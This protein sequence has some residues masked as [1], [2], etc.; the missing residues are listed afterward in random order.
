M[1]VNR[2]L[3]GAGLVLGCT[4]AL[5]ACK[6]DAFSTGPT[7]QA[8]SP[9]C[10]TIAIEVA[11][12]DG[13][14][15]GSAVVIAGAPSPDPAGPIAYSWTASAGFFLDATASRTTY[16][17]PRIGQS[18]PQAITLSATRGPCTVTQQAIVI[19]IEPA[20]VDP[21]AG[22]GAPGSRGG[23]AGAPGRSEDAGQSDDAGDGGVEG[24]PGWVTLACGLADSTIDEGNTCNQCTLDNCTTMENATGPNAVVT[25]GCH[26]LASDAAR[27][28]CERLYCCIRAHGC[29]IAST[30]DPTRCWCGDAD[31]TAC[32]LGTA[33]ATGP[34]L[35]EAKSAAH[36]T[37]LAQIN[38]SQ[39]DPALPIGG[40]V[41]LAICRA[42]F[43]STPAAPECA[44]YSK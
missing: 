36:T 38:Q 41:N 30:G 14:I 16:E 40:A 22:G 10:P 21:G 37:D 5:L 17:C 6:R 9:H 3:G 8:I 23:A 18:G 15:E 42:T 20:S 33:P 1:R 35:E 32:F 39:V 7:L 31:P 12:T 29:L 44:G 13:E 19:C 28:A 4:T 24:G 26:H 11:D 25:A 2:V 34:C 43:C 27:V